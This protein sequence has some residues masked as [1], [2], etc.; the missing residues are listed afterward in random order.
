MIIFL[1]YSKPCNTPIVSHTLCPLPQAVK[2][3]I[4]TYFAHNKLA[5][6]GLV[7]QTDILKQFTMLK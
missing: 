5:L 4:Y 2:F 7:L 1:F 6:S 3:L